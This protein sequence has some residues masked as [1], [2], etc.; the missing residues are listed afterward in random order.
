MKRHVPGLSETARD[1]HSEFRTAYFS[2]GS[3][4]RS[5]AGKPRSAFICC[6]SP[7]SNPSHLPALDRQPSLLHPKGD[8]EA[9][10]VPAGF[11]L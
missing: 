6:G 3:M 1:S 10:L 2:S 4:G 7:F 11:P 5:I 9:G 8:V